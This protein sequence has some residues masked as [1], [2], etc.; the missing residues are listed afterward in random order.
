MILLFSL[1]MVF[2][3]SLILPAFSGTVPIAIWALYF[4]SSFFSSTSLLL[5][6]STLITL[7]SLFLIIAIFSFLLPFAWF[8]LFFLFFFFLFFLY[9]FNNGFFLL[10]FL[11]L[12]GPYLVRQHNIRWYYCNLYPYGSSP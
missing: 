12:F 1:A 8:F 6:S 10:F 3:I 2:F 5:A 7:S 4:M 9:L 11:Y